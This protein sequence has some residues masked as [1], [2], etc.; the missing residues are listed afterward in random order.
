[1]DSS[2]VFSGDVTVVIPSSRKVVR[3]SSK[4]VQSQRTEAV[5]KSVP[6]FRNENHTKKS[7]AVSDLPQVHEYENPITAES[8]LNHYHFQHNSSRVAKGP[9][10]SD[11]VSEIN[12]S[13]LDKIAD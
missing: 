2:P 1:M 9:R 8:D 4:K 6:E 10:F 13:G 12:A 3:N 5:S 11:R 7:L